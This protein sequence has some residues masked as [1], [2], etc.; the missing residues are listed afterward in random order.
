MR[1]GKNSRDV[2]KSLYVIVNEA[3]K[4]RNFNQRRIT[5]GTYEG[6]LYRLQRSFIPEI[7]VKDLAK[8]IIPDNDAYITKSTQAYRWYKNDF[9]SELDKLYILLLAISNENA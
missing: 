9:A 2:E 6:Y 4:L 1:G 5:V 8:K 7:Y 3:L